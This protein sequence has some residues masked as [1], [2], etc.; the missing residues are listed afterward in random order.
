[1]N[2]SLSPTKQIQ[3]EF[4]NKVGDL[5]EMIMIFDDK[6]LFRLNYNEDE[7]LVATFSNEQHTVL[8][9]ELMFEKYW[10]EVKSLEVMNSNRLLLYS[11]L[12]LPMS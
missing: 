11:G 1:M 4:A 9:Q 2:Q 10:N 3:I 6:H 8:I 7:V 12:I 5:N